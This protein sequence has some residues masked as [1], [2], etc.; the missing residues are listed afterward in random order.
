M[1]NSLPRDP[2]NMLVNE[3]RGIVPALKSAIKEHLPFFYERFL[4]PIGIFLVVQKHGPK[5]RSAISAMLSEKPFPLFSHVEIETINRCNN[6]CSFCPV[7]RKS[8]TRPFCRMETSFFKSIIGQLSE[9]GYSGALGLFSNNEP[10]LDDRIFEFCR[11]ARESI[12]N[13]FI[14]IMTNGILLNIEKTELLMRYLDRLVIDNYDD[15]LRLIKPVQEVY[16]YCVSNNKYSDR[17]KICLRKRNEILTN[18]AGKAPNRTVRIKVASA[19][20]YPYSQ[21]IIRPDGKVSLCCNDACGMMTLGDLNTQK[22]ADV[23]RG[24]KFMTIREKLSRGRADIP[25]CSGCDSGT[26]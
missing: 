26:L 1:S 9:L 11:I 7:N 21:M 5:V 4:K 17:I 16:D 14:F 19:C 20:L 25:L 2:S 24:E 8:D 3:H 12:P 6:T 10:L 13:A 15:S 18:R 23:W 22:M